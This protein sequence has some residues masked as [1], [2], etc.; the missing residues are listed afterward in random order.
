[1]T[2]KPFNKFRIMIK[3]ILAC[4][5]L[6]LITLLA[7]AQTWHFGPKLDVNYSA[8]KGN[9]IRNKYSAGF[10]IGGFAEYN[11]SKHWAIQPELLYTWS[12][13]KKASD[14]LTYYNN[15]GR[16]AAGNNVNLAYVSVPVLV[17]YNFNKIFSI[18]AGPQYSYLIYDDEDLI[19]ENRQAVKNYE[20]SANLGV[21]VN[22]ENV[23]FY[24][25]FNKGL[26]NINDIDDRYEWKSNHVQVGIAVRIR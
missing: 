14:F 3:S 25:R 2:S 17:R 1:M 6:L 15:A 24:A 21:Q 5:A 13:Y 8:I 9:G 23:G 11:L 22:L 4:T 20:V 12:A 16:S 10:Q 19:K 7:N 26:T 18:L